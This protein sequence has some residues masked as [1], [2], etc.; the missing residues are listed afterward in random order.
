ML[1]ELT[2]LTI[3]YRGFHSVAKNNYGMSN[4]HYTTEQTPTPAA[5][6]SKLPEND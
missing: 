2:A 1:L 5:P 4:S 3:D 6:K